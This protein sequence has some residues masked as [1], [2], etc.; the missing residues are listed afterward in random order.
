[1]TIAEIIVAALV[2]AATICMV[3]T[4]LLQLRAPDALTRVNLLGPLVCIAFPILILAK[5]I[6]SWSTDG[7]SL[8][9]LIRSILA[10][11]GVWIIGSVASYIMARSIFGVTVTD[12]E[13]TPTT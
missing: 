9:D 5:L 13:A 11:F 4:M 2:I 6:F 1:M 12:K 3:A 7:F 10:V 8:G